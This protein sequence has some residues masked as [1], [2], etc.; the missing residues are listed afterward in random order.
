MNGRPAFK[1]RVYLIVIRWSSHTTMAFQMGLA[2]TL[3]KDLQEPGYLMLAKPGCGNLSALCCMQAQRKE[4]NAQEP[5]YET[6][7]PPYPSGQTSFNGH[8]C[9]L[10]IIMALPVGICCKHRLS[11]V[12]ARIPFMHTEPLR[13]TM[14]QA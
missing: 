6:S 14:T 9:S 2:W 7:K 13:L 8:H 4:F 3:G 11:P 5:R 1:I 10:S 12:Q